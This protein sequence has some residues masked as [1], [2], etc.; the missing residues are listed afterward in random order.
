MKIYHEVPGDTSSGFDCSE[1]FPYSRCYFYERNKLSDYIYLKIC[2][3]KSA[4]R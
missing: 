1:T 3:V 2:V 4:S